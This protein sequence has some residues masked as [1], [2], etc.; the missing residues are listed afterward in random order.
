DYLKASGG[1]EP[2]KKPEEQLA[3][4]AAQAEMSRGRKSAAGG[5][6]WGWLALALLFIAFCLGLWGAK[7][8]HTGS[9]NS[10]HSSQTASQGQVPLC[11]PVSSVVV[12]FPG[13]TREPV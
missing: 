5:L 12:R 4:I 8:A 7:K 13:D 3:E 11:P 6:P 1:A 2:V 9:E 10:T